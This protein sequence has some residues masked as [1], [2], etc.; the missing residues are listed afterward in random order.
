MRDARGRIGYHAREMAATTHRYSVIVRRKRVDAQTLEARVRD[1]HERLGVDPYITRVALSGDGLAQIVRDDDRAKLEQAVRALRDMGYAA[2]IVASPPPKRDVI[3]VKRFEISSG[4][5]RFHGRRGSAEVTGATAVI[6]VLAGMGADV[7]NRL[8]K[9]AALTGSAGVLSDAEKMDLLLGASPILD[10]YVIAPGAAAL[11]PLRIEPGRYDPRSLGDVASTSSRENLQTLLRLIGERAA[12]LDI[13][14][15]FGL[16][17]LPHCR[18]DPSVNDPEVLARNRAQLVH[19]GAYLVELFRQAGPPDAAKA[20]PV[21]PVEAAVAGALAAGAVAPRAIA[22]DAVA[23]AAGAAFISAAR[24]ASVSAPESTGETT[25][26]PPPPIDLKQWS[27]P[28]TSPHS[29]FMIVYW[30]AMVAWFT[31]ASAAHDVSVG[32]LRHVGLDL[33]ALFFCVAAVAFY[34]SFRALRVKRWIDH[35]PTSKARSVAMGMAELRGTARRAYNLLTPLTSQACVH[36]RLRRYEKVATSKGERERVT[37]DTSC[38][39]VPFYLDDETGT[40]LVDP[41]GAK[42]KPTHTQ[43]ID[44]EYRTPWGA[45]LVTE[46][47][48]RYVE[49]WI[50]EGASLTVLGQ[51]TDMERPVVALRDRV[52]AKL[53]ALKGDRARLAKYAANRD[54]HIDEGEW[55]TARR[56]AE[57]EAAR[58]AAEGDP[59]AAPDETAIAVRKPDHGA[60][61]FLIARGEGGRISTRYGLVAFAWMI[62]SIVAALVGTAALLDWIRF[63]PA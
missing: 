43:H 41:L 4:G 52:A 55:E 7:V 2:A 27:S 20:S 12:R 42:M 36:Y 53:R 44:G 23:L 29:L 18:Y 47:N 50:P 39:P 1:L 51:A 11:G 61:P 32:P 16:C 3:D 9:R 48:V 58:E 31:L 62:A 56:D 37:G 24:A 45:S 15:D 17:Q 13:E 49:E 46:G 5:M 60:F 34:E 28:W 14:T 30:S 10:L 19:Y 59:L 22:D 8:I 35:T 54:V 40:V 63:G 25:F 33:G 6:A 57:R 21:S 26:L 38:G